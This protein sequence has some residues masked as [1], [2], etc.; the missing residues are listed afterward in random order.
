MPVP[1][2]VDE[3]DL[4]NASKSLINALSGVSPP[5]VPFPVSETDLSNGTKA[6]LN[7]LYEAGGGPGVFVREFNGQV[8]T[9][10]SVDASGSPPSV[11]GNEGDWYFTLA[12]N[13]TPGDGLPAGWIII[14]WEYQ[15]GSWD[16]SSTLLPVAAKDLHWVAVKS[17]S[18]IEGYYVI[19]SGP[20]ETDAPEWELLGAAAVVPDDTTIGYNAAGKLETKGAAGTGTD[21][22]RVSINRPDLWDAS[23]E[24]DFGD[25][26]YGFRRT[27]VANGNAQV[28]IAM[29][30]VAVAGSAKLIAQ[31]GYVTMDNSS[32]GYVTA[33]PV[34]DSS[35]G[36][37]IQDNSYGINLIIAAISSGNR[38]NAPYDVWVT[39]TK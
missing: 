3:N 17:G 33:Y 4:S 35:K 22:S 7:A 36:F 27:G 26:L 24:I 1:Y 30:S 20:E 38:T 11:T 18:G 10:V 14:A 32:P 2:P 23:I 31:G 8:G 6:I 19:L 13:E 15:G 5:G 16:F 28:N 34:P 9:G 12:F 21:G 37:I 29:L 25:G 39:Y